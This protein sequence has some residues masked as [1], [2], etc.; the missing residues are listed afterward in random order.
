VVGA[1]SARLGPPGVLAGA[2]RRRRR[3]GAGRAR[4]AGPALVDLGR[5]ARADSKV[6]TRQPL[7]RALVSRRA[8]P[9]CRRSCGRWWPPS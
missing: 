2:G 8:S 1:R 6:R 9:R 4:G 5:A 3:R 7:G